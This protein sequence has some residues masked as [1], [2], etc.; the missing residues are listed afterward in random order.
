[1]NIAEIDII[2]RN[3]LAAEFLDQGILVIPDVSLPEG[4][5]P[6]ATDVVFL[7]VDGVCEIYVDARVGYTGTVKRWHEIVAGGEYPGNTR[8]IAR[9]PDYFSAWRTLAHLLAAEQPAAQT[10]SVGNDRSFWLQRLGLAGNPTVEQIKKAYRRL[11]MLHHPDRMS[12]ATPTELE[13]AGERMREI[14]EAHTA[15]MCHNQGG[16]G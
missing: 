1:M 7:A 15:L 8:F 14:T 10:E 12:G 16:R 11:A 13:A 5:D 9:S 3:T 6:R 4:F 2:T